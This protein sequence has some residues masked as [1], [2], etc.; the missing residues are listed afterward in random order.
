MSDIAYSITA[1]EQQVPVLCTL[2][3]L[4]KGPQFY[5]EK[6]PTFKNIVHITVPYLI[7]HVDQ[8]L[9]H[10]IHTSIIQE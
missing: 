10:A 4:R 9:L 3:R 6:Q 1:Q 7:L 5:I 2:L 8:D